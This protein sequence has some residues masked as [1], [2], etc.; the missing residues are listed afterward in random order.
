MEDSELQAIRQARMAQ[1][2]SG[3]GGGAGPSGAGSMPAGLPAGAQYRGGGGGGAGGAGA[4]DMDE[5][6][7]RQQMAQQDEMKREMLSTVLEPEARERLSRINLVKPGKARAI[8]DMLIRMAQQGQIRSKISEAQLI[9]LLDQVDRSDQQRN[10]A[11]AGG[12]GAGAGSK[13]TFN[14]KKTAVEDDSDDDF[15]L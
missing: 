4:A 9:D 10:G 6:E 3:S 2:R 7:R 5:D 1:L 13:I 15:D 14:R 8:Q 12:A 11:G